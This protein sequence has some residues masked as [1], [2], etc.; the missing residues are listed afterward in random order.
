MYVYYWKENPR[1]FKFSMKSLVMTLCKFTTGEEMLYN[2]HLW[3]IKNH[4]SSLIKHL[5]NSITE[6]EPLCATWQQRI[7]NTTLKCSDG[8]TVTC[9]TWFPRIFLS[10]LP[11]KGC[12]SLKNNW[13]TL[14]NWISVLEFPSQS[15]LVLPLQ[16]LWSGSFK[17]PMFRLRYLEPVSEYLFWLFSS[18]L[19]TS[20]STTK[21]KMEHGL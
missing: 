12:V 7:G 4:I 8:H 21:Y 19:W 11:L 6:K 17:H 2:E 9:H 16:R 20:F 3:T 5:Y 18:T 14:R 15:S 13:F 1:K 10:P